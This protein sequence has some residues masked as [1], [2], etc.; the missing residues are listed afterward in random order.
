[1]TVSSNLARF[2]RY[3]ATAPLVAILRGAHLAEVESLVTRLSWRP[4]C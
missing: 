2:E 1:M 4:S 3:F